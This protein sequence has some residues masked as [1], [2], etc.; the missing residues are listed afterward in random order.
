MI[1]NLEDNLRRAKARH[2]VDEEDKKVER[3]R[4]AE[5]RHQREIE[6]KRAEEENL[7]RQI[8]LLKNKTHAVYMGDLTKRSLFR[9]LIAKPVEIIV[10]DFSCSENYSPRSGA[11]GDGGG[12]NRYIE[13]AY[14]GIASER[15]PDRDF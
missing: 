14:R 3:A 6:E 9:I 7:I 15:R 5:E 1:S 11:F 12:G 10:G 2:M 8:E 4:Q 13:L